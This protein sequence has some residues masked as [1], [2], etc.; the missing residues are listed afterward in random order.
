MKLIAL[1]EV[2]LQLMRFDDHIHIEVQPFEWLLGSVALRDVERY[3]LNAG[4]DIR[5]TTS[6]NDT[7]YHQIAA[8][9]PAYFV[10]EDAHGNSVSQGR[11][12]QTLQ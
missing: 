9:Y 4:D 10:L 11:S 5:F 3:H 8:D 2:W 7:P 1:V 12:S 6:H